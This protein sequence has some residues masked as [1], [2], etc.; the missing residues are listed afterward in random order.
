MGTVRGRFWLES[1]LAL[2]CG[3][4]A[5]VTLVWRDWVEALTGFDPDGHN[6]WVEWLVVAVFAVS[7]LVVGVAARGELRRAKLVLSVRGGS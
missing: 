7:A 4:L 1:G 2:G 5:G 6:G 3:I